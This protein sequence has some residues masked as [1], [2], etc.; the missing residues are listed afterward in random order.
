M[1]PPCGASGVKGGG[2]PSG[3]TRHPSSATGSSHSGQN[4]LKDNQNSPSSQIWDGRMAK[5][6][7]EKEGT[8]SVWGTTSL[9]GQDG[10]TVSASKNPQPD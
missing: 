10:D 3:I 9:M 4:E 7:M 5:T 1:L 2:G 8:L 6:E